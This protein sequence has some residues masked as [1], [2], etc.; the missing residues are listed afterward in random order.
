[1]LIKNERNQENIAV[2][3]SY[4]HFQHIRQRPLG[5]LKGKARYKIHHDFTLNDEELLLV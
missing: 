5:V 2:I 1:V 4:Q 3:I